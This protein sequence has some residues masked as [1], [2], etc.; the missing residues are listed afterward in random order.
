MRA[1]A[2]MIASGLLARGHQIHQRTAPLLFGRLFPLHHPLAK[3]L[4][5]IDQFIIFPPLLWL[6]ALCLPPGSLCVL[7]DQALGP[8]FP[9][10]AGRPH[11]VHC[12]DLLALEASLG[13]QPFHQL[14]PSGRTYQRWISRGFSRARCFLSV[15]AATQAALEPHLARPPL[16]S[17]V[18]YN[19]L[20][21]RFASAP[22][23]ASAAAVA[24]EL[25]NLGSQPFLFHIG[26]NWYKNRLGV[27]AIWEQLL[28]L[29]SSVSLVL[30]GTL[31]QAMRDWLI[32]RPQLNS[33]VYVLKSPSDALV[34]ALYH[35]ASALLFPSHAEGFGWPILEALACGCP[36]LTTSR[37]PMTEVGGIAATYISPAPPPPAPLE[38]WAEE[39]AQVLLQMLQR[40][41]A[42]Q[43]QVRQLGQ[44]QARRFQ[45]ESWLQQ[46]EAHYENALALQEDC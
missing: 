15:S 27:F 38:P 17:E 9:W 10:L 32:E 16:L 29:G 40:T 18:L 4:G 24:A 35:Q 43:A 19:P 41:P 26:R 33:L 3:W 6:E 42:E 14:S 13:L 30:V 34:T 1:Y 11:L 25:P 22:S 21:P 2:E 37:A 8:W 5:Y 44:A 28:R 23:G 7:A 31:D 45:S 39:A 20:S 46:L 36:V 12:H